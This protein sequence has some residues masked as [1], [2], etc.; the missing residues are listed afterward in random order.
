MPLSNKDNPLTEPEPAPKKAKA[1][2]KPVLLKAS[3][4][5]DAGVQNLLARREVASDEAAIAAIDAELA[6]LGFTV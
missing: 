3:T 2:P 1:E 5:G 6:E 4:T